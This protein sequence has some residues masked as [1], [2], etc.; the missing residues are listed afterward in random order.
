MSIPISYLKLVK[1]QTREKR[2]TT[3]CTARKERSNEIRT[4]CAKTRTKTF[5]KSWTRVWQSN[6]ATHSRYVLELLNS[7][8]RRPELANRKV[9]RKRKVQ[10]VVPA[11]KNQW[12]QSK[13]DDKISR[14][15]S[16][17]TLS[18][19][20]TDNAHL[21]P[22]RTLYY[23]FLNRSGCL[24]TQHYRLRLSQAWMKSVEGERLQDSRYLALPW[25]LNTAWVSERQILI[26]NIGDNFMS[27]M[28]KTKRNR[29]IVNA[30][31]YHF[32]QAR[33]VG[34]AKLC[35]KQ[36]NSGVP[37]LLLPCTNLAFRQMSMYPFRI[38]TDEHMPLKFLMTKYFIMIIH[39]FFK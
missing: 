27:S 34:V 30:S 13:T 24:A 33:I 18:T 2:L 39:R 38:S 4:Y 11:T 32:K 21:L 17:C 1:R 14:M 5:V 29:G 37:N 7:N 16:C 19:T 23:K 10:I 15:R 26:F 8:A 20:I 3:S 25:K 31:N 9:I 28:R 12:L 6:F 22:V 36:F 35:N